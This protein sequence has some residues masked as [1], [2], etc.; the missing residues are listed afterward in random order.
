MEI[1]ELSKWISEEKK[2]IEYLRK[3]KILKDYKQCPHCN[4]KKLWETK[5]WRYKC[6]N[7][8]KEWSIRKGSILSGFKISF[9]KFLTA[10]KLFEM[11]TTALKISKELEISYKTTLKILKIFRKN[12]KTSETKK[13]FSG[14]IEL[15]ESYFGGRSKENK[16]RKAKSKIPVFGILER[17]GRIHVE[18]VENVDSKTLLGLTI[19]KVKRGSLIYTDCFKSYDGLVNY[20]FK[21]ERINK[22]KTFA[23]GK[24]YVNGIEGF[25][26][27][28]KRRLLKYHGVG[29][30]NF[31]YY[32]KELEFRYNNRKNNLFDCIINELSYLKK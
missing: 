25:W 17:T 15:D 3:K 29:K 7:C 26:G 30:S 32:L 23:N 21:H 19:K 2:A 8:F 20:G 27:Y 28:T 9:V 12:I 14:E 6:S 5:R 31:I 4:N 16:G 10:I 24:V 18:I 11:E 13:D 22:T 1:L